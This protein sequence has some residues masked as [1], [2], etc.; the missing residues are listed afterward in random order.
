MKMLEDLYKKGAA[1]GRSIPTKRSI[2]KNCFVVFT[3]TS[4]SLLYHKLIIRKSVFARVPKSNLYAA[5]FEQAISKPTFRLKVSKKFPQE[6]W[7]LWGRIDRGRGSHNGQPLPSQWITAGVADL[8]FFYVYAKVARHSVSTVVLSPVET[9][10]ISVPSMTRCIQCQLCS[11]D[12]ESIQGTVQKAG[13]TIH[14]S[15]GANRRD[16]PEVRRCSIWTDVCSILYWDRWFIQTSRWCFQQHHP[17][18]NL[19]R[20]AGTIGKSWGRWPWVRQCLWNPDS[21]SRCT[22]TK[23]GW[24]WRWRKT[25]SQEIKLIPLIATHP[26]VPSFC[27]AYQVLQYSKDS[28]FCSKWIQFQIPNYLHY[29]R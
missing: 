19:C 25:C 23:S 14:K 20:D 11:R 9:D 10:C 6:N 8:L 15:A 27:D 3:W 18:R 21:Q 22:G 13:K 29:L 28:L 5:P 1:S 7:F 24:C 26:V 17:Q 4:D 16:L 12:S 2:W